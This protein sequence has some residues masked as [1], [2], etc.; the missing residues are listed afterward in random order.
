[1]RLPSEP[2]LPPQINVVPMIDVMFALLTFFIMSV[3]TL[4]KS[5][6]LPVNLPKAAT[7]QSQAKNQIGIT[8][9]PA[10]KLA[11]NKQPIQL[12][13]IATQVRQLIATNP[14]TVVLINADEQV[15]H[16]RV[17]AVMD[18]VRQV[19]GARLAIATQRQSP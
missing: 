15:S 16:G 5:A 3:L 12:D 6:G 2:D 17:V 18:Q 9:D 14:Q 10:G 11:L 13:Q 4:T 7:S 1:M 8:I 19:P